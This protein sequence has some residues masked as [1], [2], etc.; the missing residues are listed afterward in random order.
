MLCRVYFLILS[1]FLVFPLCAFAGTTIRTVLIEVPTPCHKVDKVEER[2]VYLKSPENPCI[3]VVTR[4]PV[5]ID[6]SSKDT[7]LRRQEVDI[8]ID[9]IFWTEQKI[10]DF[11]LK[12]IEDYM[13]KV[14]GYKQGLEIPENIHKKQGQ[15]EAEKLSKY[16]YS[17]EYQKKLRD[18]S[19][20]LK[21]EM[22]NE[23]L[24][25][26]YSDA[27]PLDISGNLGFNQRIYIFI[28]SS[29]PIETI[30]NYVRDVDKIGDRNIVFIMR[31][32]I[33]GMKYIKPTMN[34][35]AKTILK[36]TDCNLMREECETYN[37][38]FEI[39]P[40]L[41]KRYQISSVP[42]F[43]YVEHID[44][45]DIDM[46]EG[47]KENVSASNYYTVYGDASL[48]HIF[49][50]LLKATKSPS[51]EGLLLTLK[52]GFYQQKPRRK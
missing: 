46:S 1:L 23:A 30:R 48:E 11:N 51:I 10:T 22:F 25:G 43:V 17:E 28:S 45:M 21:R 50:V 31:G 41:F 29:I 32:F 34:F 49:D 44:V 2:K 12:D 24:K 3:Q 42:A 9:G 19:A 39:D 47:E 18:E 5:K 33:D 16:F 6:F 20:G 35:I 37:V 36:D 27:K 40:L 52:K 14:E 15:E 4:I 8:Y 26:Y 38:S 13:D 7:A